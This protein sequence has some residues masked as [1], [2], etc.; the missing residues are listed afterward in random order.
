MFSLKG[1]EK[2]ASLKS[3]RI[4]TKDNKDEYSKFCFLLFPLNKNKRRESIAKFNDKYITSISPIWHFQLS[5]L[6]NY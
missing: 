5:D 4:L 1:V 2:K 6:H 3:S